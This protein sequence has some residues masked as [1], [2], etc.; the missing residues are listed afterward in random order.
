MPNQAMYSDY[1]LIYIW[2]ITFGS[3]GWRYVGRF[4]LRSSISATWAGWGPE[5]ELGIRCNTK[6]RDKRKEL[7]SDL[8]CWRPLNIQVWGPGSVFDTFGDFQKVIE[9][10]GERLSLT[11]APLI[12]NAERILLECDSFAH[13]TFSFLFLIGFCL[14]NC[15]FLYV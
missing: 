15:R 8:M 11:E 5:T 9:S 13:T 7:D 6:T 12:V 10:N 1:T 4:F 3:C 14:C 2:S